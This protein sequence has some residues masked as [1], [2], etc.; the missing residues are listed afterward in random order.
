MRRA[1]R[2]H[3]RQHEAKELDTAAAGRLAAA[4]ADNGPADDAGG[5]SWHAN[6]LDPPIRVTDGSRDVKVDDTISRVPGAQSPAER[7]RL[8]TRRAEP[9]KHR[10]DEVERGDRRLS[11]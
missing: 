7:R 2:P 1:V 10:R 11:P 5:S 3:V 6:A 9:K 4:A 8:D